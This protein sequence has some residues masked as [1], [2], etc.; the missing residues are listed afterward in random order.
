MVSYKIQLIKSLKTPKW[1]SCNKI[2]LE[3][4]TALAITLLV[5]YSWHRKNLK[6]QKSVWNQLEEEDA[7]YVK[8]N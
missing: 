7:T 4:P 6:Q 5:Q 2:A 3:V 1:L 8:Q